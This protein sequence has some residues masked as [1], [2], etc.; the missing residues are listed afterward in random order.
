VHSYVT[1]VFSEEPLPFAGCLLHKE[2]KETTVGLLKK[3][4]N[5]IKPNAF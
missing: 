5:L 1:S 2:V 4:K 3:M